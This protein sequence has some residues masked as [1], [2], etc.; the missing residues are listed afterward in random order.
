MMAYRKEGYY[1]VELFRGGWE[2]AK[3]DGHDWLRFGIE[4]TINGYVKRVGPEI[5][6]PKDY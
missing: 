4:T 6:F 5:T 2:P 1:W 3:W